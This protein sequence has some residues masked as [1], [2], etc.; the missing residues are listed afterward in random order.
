M[1][2]IVKKTV[3]GQHKKN[4]QIIEEVINKNMSKIKKLAKKKKKIEIIDDSMYCPIC[5]GCGF[6]GC[7]GVE[8]FL[9][10]HVRGKTNC[11]Q[12]GLFIDE[13]KELWEQ[14]KPY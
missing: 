5:G 13:I 10:K 9:E 1:E 8:E 6:I 3:N 7:C 14:N 11:P 12:E 4:N 2:I